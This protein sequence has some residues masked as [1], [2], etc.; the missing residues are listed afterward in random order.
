MTMADIIVLILTY[1]VAGIIFGA[2]IRRLADA[3]KSSDQLS[4]S[5]CL[6]TGAI[7]APVA[8]ALLLW[9]V[10]ALFPGAGP[11]A[12]VASISVV[13][14]TL[15]AVSLRQVL[16]CVSAPFKWFCLKFK[17]A[18]LSSRICHV[19]MTFASSA[20]ICHVFY[21][22]V[23]LP[24]V[25]H[26]ASVYA[27]YG[28]DIF[29]N[30]SLQNYPV[31]DPMLAKSGCLKDE[32]PPVYPLIQ[33]W[34]YMVKGSC[35][36]DFPA[37]TVSPV[38]G[39]YLVILIAAFLL[40]RGKGSITAAVILFAATPL[41]YFQTIGNG[42]DPLRISTFFLAAYLLS[43]FLDTPSIFM[44]IL[45]GS[46]CA[47]AASIHLGNVVL[48]PLAL[49]VCAANAH[50]IG[51]SK[52]MA[53]FLAAF[54]LANVGLLGILAG[55]GKLDYFISLKN[56]DSEI[57]S[58]SR[59]NAFGQEW[60]EQIKAGDVSK[61]SLIWKERLQLF[62]RT[63]HFGLTFILG[64]AGL[65]L[66]LF[67]PKERI[68]FVMLASWV[69][70]SILAISTFYINYRYVSTV[71]PAAVFFFALGA[72]QACETIRSK[73]PG[74]FNAAR[75]SISSAFLAVMSALLMYGLIYSSPDCKSSNLP[76]N[77]L[78]AKFV[79]L[80][81]WKLLAHP[82]E[83]AVL[84]A[85]SAAGDGTILLMGASPEALY[86][87]K[88]KDVISARNVE[89][90]E[91]FI[92]N[93]KLSEVFLSDT[94]E[95][96]PSFEKSILPELLGRNEYFRFR[97]YESGLKSYSCSLEYIPLLEKI[98]L[99]ALSVTN[100]REKVL[101]VDKKSSKGT[102][103][104][105]K[106]DRIAYYFN[107]DFPVKDFLELKS[108]SEAWKFLRKRNI[109]TVILNSS[110]DD[111][112]FVSDSPFMLLVEDKDNFINISSEGIFSLFKVGGKYL[113]SS[114]LRAILADALRITPKTKRILLVSGR[115][116]LIETP[117]VEKRLVCYFSS[118]FP[119]DRFVKYK[120]VESAMNEL[121]RQ[122]IDTVVMDK[123]YEQNTNYMNSKLPLILNNPETSL[124][125]GQKD[126]FSLCKVAQNVSSFQK[127]L[128]LSAVTK[129]PDGKILFIGSDTGKRELDDLP[130][131]VIKYF[132]SSFPVKTFSKL[133]TRG[134]VIR[135]LKEWSIKK[136]I[137]DSGFEQNRFFKG[138][139][140]SKMLADESCAKMIAREGEYRAYGLSY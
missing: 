119:L 12:C 84:K 65:A 68:D 120:D 27:Y 51:I 102:E 134:K 45:M 44:F 105:N 39:L 2:I 32:H 40:R 126:A 48:F 19:V 8:I 66:W 54:L 62:S 24:I 136:V 81:A 70:F 25:G 131:A 3:F 138:T 137:I 41:F 52:R 139:Q 110:Y 114:S 90:A 94:F 61:G 125:L 133:N 4:P 97:S 113:P 29:E 34:F 108:A 85:S 91:S 107:S 129:E 135:T 106:S 89:E 43:R 18:A 5:E 82:Y 92:S 101:L 93:F 58:K 30:R 115:D 71:I 57:S 16:E 100:A 37:R 56:V 76:Q 53:G 123:R 17:G 63:S 99:A 26:D 86:Y 50:R 116:R 6:L 130:D 132:H 23:A 36:E 21:Q 67:R 112:R 95:D 22:A 140:F 74:A 117:E 47:A 83:F 11:Q 122:S 73:H 77:S 75:I 38:Y 46:A 1:P 104:F 59:I 15:L 124:P 72:G 69:L 128:Y 80:A 111:N 87:L 31:T 7:L 127:I 78:P 10:L 64:F 33:A 96:D 98:I 60:A 20:F 13:F 103:M 42:I 49:L 35:H 109:G 9:A 121:L 55:S 28:K 14:T 118:N 88:D 79:K